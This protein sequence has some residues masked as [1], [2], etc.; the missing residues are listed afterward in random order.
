MVIVAVLLLNFPDAPDPGAV[1]VT[2]APLTGLLKESRTVATSGAANAVLI[3]ALC[4]V[5]LVAVMVAGTP[6]A[7][8]VNFRWK[9]VVPPSPRNEDTMKK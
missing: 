5:P 3:A 1:K 7:P 9:F 2:F 4:G 6:A 8:V